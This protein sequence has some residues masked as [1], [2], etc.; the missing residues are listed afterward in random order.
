MERKTGLFSIQR[1]PFREVECFASGFT[2]DKTSGVD[3]VKGMKYK[4]GR[5][6]RQLLGEL[7]IE[8]AL[9]D[10]PEAGDNDSKLVNGDLPAKEPKLELELELESE[11]E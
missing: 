5:R 10:A 4:K 11:P 3:R 9:D 1:Y 2:E 8:E 6:I 7:R